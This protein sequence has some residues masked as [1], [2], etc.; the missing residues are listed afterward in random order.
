MGSLNLNRCKEDGDFTDKEVQIL[1]ILEPHITNR[2][3]RW[4]VRVQRSSS[5]SVFVRRFGISPREAEVVR[6][7]MKGM[8]HDEI[9]AALS[10][11]TGTA[12][13]HLENIFKKTHVNSRIELIVLIQGC[14]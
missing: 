4:H 5:E 13:K 14:I 8:S 7:V 6:C 1:R 10:I 2:L 3:S 11:S 12:K 9:A